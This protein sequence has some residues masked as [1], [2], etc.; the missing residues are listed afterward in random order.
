MHKQVNTAG[1]PCIAVS[2]SFNF[3]RSHACD[4][5]TCCNHLAGGDNAGINTRVVCKESASGDLTSGPGRTGA[6]LCVL[7]V[8]MAPLAIADMDIIDVGVGLQSEDEADQVRSGQQHR[9]CV[10]QR[11]EKKKVLNQKRV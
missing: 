7:T 6:C 2:R 10:H 8:C 9:D 1:S 5:H 11:P 3:K 4:T